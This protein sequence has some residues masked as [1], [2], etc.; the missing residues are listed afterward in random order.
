MRFVALPRTAAALVAATVW[1]VSMKFTADVMLAPRIPDPSVAATAS[2]ATCSLAQ[3]R[4]L[5]VEAGFGVDG[6]LTFVQ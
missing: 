2:T 6:L 1:F 4:S 5:A 3:S